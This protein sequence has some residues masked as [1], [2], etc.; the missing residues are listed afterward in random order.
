MGKL[1]DIDYVHDVLTV[2]TSRTCA[3]CAGQIGKSRS[4]IRCVLNLQNIRYCYNPMLGGGKTSHCWSLNLSWQILYYGWQWSTE[5]EHSYIQELSGVG[6]AETFL[7]LTEY[8]FEI[9]RSR[10]LFRSTVS[11]N[12]RLW[13]MEFVPKMFVVS[14]FLSPKFAQ[15][16]WRCMEWP[17]E[18]FAG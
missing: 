18:Q 7:T 6:W 13:D 16:P 5:G 10:V 11:A 9:G 15:N 4:S 14:W 3:T 12:V 8:F 17:R 2:H 1:C